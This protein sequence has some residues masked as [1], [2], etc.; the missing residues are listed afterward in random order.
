MRKRERRCAA[1]S[2]QMKITITIFEKDGNL[3]VKEGETLLRFV[4]VQEFLGIVRN[5]DKDG[6]VRF[7]ENE[8]GEIFAIGYGGR[9]LPRV[10]D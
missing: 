3:A 9:M 6:Y 7:F 2:V 4:P 5:P 8:N 1:P 10:K